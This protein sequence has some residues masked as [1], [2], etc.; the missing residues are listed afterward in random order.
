MSFW[1][2]AQEKFSIFVTFSQEQNSR[3]KHFLMIFFLS[4]SRIIPIFPNDDLCFLCVGGAVGGD[5]VTA[6]LAACASQGGRGQ[7]ATPPCA[8]HNAWTE[9]NF[10]ENHL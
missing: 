1:I 6:T 4:Y 8:H 7:T 5:S 3:K 2:I 9:V 10:Q